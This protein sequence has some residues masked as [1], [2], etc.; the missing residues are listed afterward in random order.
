MPHA[1]R[2]PVLGKIMPLNS[3]IVGA[4][5][6]LIG[7]SG[8][9][10]GVSGGRASVTALIPAFFGI[11]MILL[12]IV[13]QMKETLRPHLMHAAVLIALLGFILTA[14]RLAMKISTIEM[15]AAVLSQTAMAIVCLVFVILGIMSFVKARQERIG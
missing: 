4:I 6:V 3:I 8:Y 15:S 11:V 13:S 14:G 2:P 5:L 12:G 9:L 10:Y 1:W 7:V